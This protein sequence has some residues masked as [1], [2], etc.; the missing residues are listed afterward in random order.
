MTQTHLNFLL[1]GLFPKIFK[2]IFWGGGGV[3]RTVVLTQFEYVYL[4]KC[5]FL[6]RHVSSGICPIDTQFCLRLVESMVREYQT[7]RR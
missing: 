6:S 1:F 5:F 7:K 4:Q 2:V 3:P